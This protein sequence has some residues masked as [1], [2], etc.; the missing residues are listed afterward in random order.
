MDLKERIKTAN[1]T[2]FMLQKCFGNKNVSGKLKLILKKTITDKALTYTSEIRI[3]KN[4]DRKQINIF[5]M[6]V[7]RGILG[8]VYDKESMLENINQ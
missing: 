4:R 8:P 7:Y 3:L 6:K 2:H 1:K 5:E